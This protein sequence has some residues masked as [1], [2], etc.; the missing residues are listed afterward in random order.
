VPA[1]QFGHIGQ[2]VDEVPR[3][4]AEAQTVELREESGACSLARSRLSS[5]DA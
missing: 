1:Q 5:P 2:R 4:N 3:A